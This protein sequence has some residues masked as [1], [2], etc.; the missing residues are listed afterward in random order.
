MKDDALSVIV[1]GS[2]AAIGIPSYLVW[3]RQEIDLSLRV[4]LTHSAERFLQPQ[5]V[6][7]WPAIGRR[8][9]SRP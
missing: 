5:V 9:S 6:G 4:L 3:L 7:C 1:S 2:S 8:S